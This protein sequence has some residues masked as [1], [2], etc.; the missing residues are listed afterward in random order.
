LRINARRVSWLEET[1]AKLATT[2][3]AL[4]AYASVR[5]T[6]VLDLIQPI[7]ISHATRI[8]A[9][10]ISAINGKGAIQSNDLYNRAGSATATRPRG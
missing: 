6:I 5:K 10:G 3:F 4:Q 8:T 9:I 7:R 1:L 2:A